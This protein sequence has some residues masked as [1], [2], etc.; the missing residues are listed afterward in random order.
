MFPPGVQG[1]TGIRY[2]Q[3][4][5]LS[6]PKTFQAVIIDTPDTSGSIHSPFKQP[7]GRRLARGG[8]AVA[9]GM[10]SAHAVDPVVAGLKLSADNTSLE[11][12]VAS[13]GSMLTI[14]TVLGLHF[15]FRAFLFSRVSRWSVF[16]PPGHACKWAISGSNLT[17]WAAVLG[18]F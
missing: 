12:S 18:G 2:A 6:M 10:A 1:F 11:V 17:F 5:T 13:G 9:Y 7:V 16:S 14:F 8:L 15:K 4:N 3:T